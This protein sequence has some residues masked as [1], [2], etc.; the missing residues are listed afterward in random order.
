[1]VYYLLLLVGLPLSNICQSLSQKQYTMKKESVNVILF[2][3]VTTAVALCFFLI[4]SGFR[5]DFTL[6]QLPYSLVFAVAYAAGCCGYFS[7]SCHAAFASSSSR[8]M[9]RQEVRLA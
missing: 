1:M 5:L 9:V 8:S 3:A 7:A 4:T 2:S 6:R